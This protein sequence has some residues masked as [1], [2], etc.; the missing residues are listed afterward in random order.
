MQSPTTKSVN[1]IF[2]PYAGASFY[3]YR[4]FRKYLPDFIQITAIDL[5]GHGKRMNELLLTDIHEIVK[6]IFHQIKDL[7]EKPYAFYGH[8]M[9]ASLG[10]LLTNFIADAG[11]FAQPRHLFFSGKSGPM[12]EE[13]MTLHKLPKRDLINALLA[14]GGIPVEVLDYEELLDLFLPILR[15][16]FQ[17]LGNYVYESAV[18]LDI[19]MTVM[20][21]TEDRLTQGKEIQWMETTKRELVIKQF[22][23]SHFFIFDHLPEI[24]RMISDSLDRHP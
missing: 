23:G 5:P 15:A 4:D 11:A 16:D 18:P 2:L 14:F 20:L 8:S 7:L 10:Y 22:Q 12:A 3:A 6:D 9:G 24:C 13:E 1:L 17:A 21:G 19:P